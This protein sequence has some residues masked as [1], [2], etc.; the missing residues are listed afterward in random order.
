MGEV[1]STNDRKAVDAKFWS[2]YLK[3][4]L[5]YAGGQYQNGFHQEKQ[6]DSEKNSS[7][8]RMEPVVSSC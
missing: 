5:E 2:E 6:G 8:A 4:V 3:T 1:R 7:D